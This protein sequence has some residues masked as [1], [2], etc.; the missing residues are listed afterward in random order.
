MPEG[1]QDIIREAEAANV[2]KEWDQAIEL[3][4]QVLEADP[5][6]EES[7][8]KLA[9]LYAIRGLIS[10][11]IEQ[12]FTLMDI[13]EEKD[14]HELAVEVARWIM[15][16]QPDNDKA[17]MKTILI[18]KKKGDLDEVVKQSLQLARLYIE[19][20]QGDQSILLLKNAQEI[21]PDNLDIGL[22]LAEMYISHGHIPE[23]TAQYKKIANAFLNTGNYEKAAEAFRRMKVV[24]PDDPQ[25][26][27]TLGN[28]YVN[29]G[30]L[31]EAESEFRAILRHD[32]NHTEALMAL[33]NV[34]QRKG[35]FRDAILAFNKIL[36]VDQQ[37]E[38]A[39]EKLGELY[40]A[41]G[42]TS[43]AVK[44]YLQAA[45]A[46]QYGEAVDRAIKL[47]QRV[48]TIDPTNPTAC[49]E[50]TNLGASLV[51]EEQEAE[52]IE[53]YAPVISPL[54][55]D[56]EELDITG[57]SL[58]EMAG[59]ILP[60]TTTGIPKS[61]RKAG[62]SEDEEE[63][64]PEDVI[65]REEAPIGAI[66]SQF[67]GMKSEEEEFQPFMRGVGDDL[68]YS[69]R[70]N[71]S[72]IQYREQVREQVIEEQEEVE[73]EEYIEEAPT[74]KARRPKRK[75]LR[76][77]EQY[78]QRTSRKGLVKKGLFLKEEDEKTSKPGLLRSKGKSRLGAKK[79]LFS[80]RSPTKGLLRRH[81]RG[82]EEVE[83]APE[84]EEIM[85]EV[86]EV[87]PE[88]EDVREEKVPEEYTE[89]YHEEYSEEYPEEYAE[90]YAEEYP[91]EYPSEIQ[92]EEVPQYEETITEPQPMEEPLPTPVME[93]PQPVEEYPHFE[94]MPLEE[95]QEEP[96]GFDYPEEEEPSGFA[97]V[98]G[99]LQF[100]DQ[101]LPQ[102]EEEQ[103]PEEMPT[104]EEEVV[105]EIE[106]PLAL[107][108]E[109]FQQK[110]LI[111]IKKKPLIEV[112]GVREAPTPPV[113]ELLVEEA[114]AIPQMPEEPEISQIPMMEE[115]EEEE[116][117]Y[118][119]DFAELPLLELPEEIVAEYPPE[120]EIPEMPFP[121]EEEEYSVEQFPDEFSEDMEIPDLDLSEME[122]G[123]PVEEVIPTLED[124]IPEVAEFPSALKPFEEVTPKPVEEL[125]TTEPISFEDMSLPD[126]GEGGF[127][128]PDFSSFGFE[129]PPDTGG[130][131]FTT[132]LLKLAAEIEQIIP[133]DERIREAEEKKRQEEEERK[134]WEEKKK[135]AELSIKKVPK[136]EFLPPPKVEISR[137]TTFLELPGEDEEISLSVLPSLPGDMDTGEVQIA[138]STAIT[139][140]TVFLPPLEIVIETGPPAQIVEE[141]EAPPEIEIEEEEVIGE[142]IEEPPAPE[143][144]VDIEERLR[145][146]VSAGDLG[147][148]F[149]L[150]VEAMEKKP[151]NLELRREYADLCYSYGMM[152]KALENYKILLEKETKNFEIRRKMIKGQLLYNYT[153]DAVVSLL[154]Y[155]NEL[156]GED[157]IDEAQRIYQYVLALKEKNPHA[158]ES[159][160]EIYLNLDMKELA[161]FHLKI[162]SNYLEE[163]KS[164]DRAI[165]VLRK[166][167]SLTSN[168]KIQ[169]R[170][171]RVYIENDYKDEA[172]NAIT[173]L[174]KRYMEKK[175]Y[176]K[177]ATN[178]E[179]IIEMDSQHLDAHKHLIDLYEQLGDKNRSYQEKVTVA[180]LVIAR[181]DMDEAR[182]RFEECLSIRL[183][184]Q[185]VRR[186]IVGIYLR[187][188]NLKK[189]LE[190][191]R[192]LSEFYHKQR[193]YN[194]AIELYLEL[195][196]ADPKNLALRDKLSEFYVMSDQ[197]NKGLDQLILIAEE[198]TRLAEWNQAIKAY[199]KALTIDS[200][201]P[202]LH[203][204][205][206]EIY[207]NQKK[208]VTEARY[209]FAQ[210]F[211]LD[212][213]HR[214]AMEYLVK[215][216]LREEK[217]SKATRVLKRL[218]E[219]DSSYNGMKNEIIDHYLT[220]IKKNPSDYKL[221]FYLGIVYKELRMWKQAIEQFQQTR[222]SNDY[223]LE[224][225]SM[226]GVCFAQQPPMR[227]LAIKTL[228]KGLQLPG[229][230]PK[231]YIELHYQLAL[232]YEKTRKYKKALEELQAVVSLDSYYKDAAEVLKKVK[233][234]IKY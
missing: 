164:I 54:E 6:N 88:Y 70:K 93:E 147:T 173:G 233:K 125:V 7:C 191:S 209:E 219:L 152:D 77:K 182:Q 71:G 16:L 61:A 23:G 45:N 21:A 90:E 102:V 204:K 214:K 227:N 29:L 59:A 55:L 97:D 74:R 66:P 222:K 127:D 87:E 139:P 37:N 41:Q 104:F 26:M 134:A 18:Y 43:E 130:D 89:E 31:N 82:E 100:L 68:V 86:P 76:K 116:E 12:Y 166:I 64:G 205:I 1:V 181:G 75:G 225:H 78:D 171:T 216:Y 48:L 213:T 112:I 33:G 211:E 84:M 111:G 47:Y 101:Q 132:S 151:D 20:G 91:Q 146:S 24:Q 158:R 210:V 234:K 13:L 145:E 105:E 79:G 148:A 183:D 207:L 73:E 123:E 141:I 119:E 131:D 196:K 169:E 159:L 185:E 46:Y 92:E 217:P 190:E 56:E 203:F 22:E 202:D 65:D 83:V 188:S 229:F 9:E 122:I 103:I 49:R 5:K 50:L 176:M 51:S 113:M 32:L 226:L 168:I 195:V 17:R 162:L 94:A 186:K 69:G 179:K 11:V 81:A 206:G 184:D 15:K 189:A 161:L 199:K 121:Q 155:G 224:S 124:E 34:C 172:I 128:L 36:S 106:E 201:N 60:P 218:I 154:E 44:F 63:F 150:F 120:E 231:D 136:E 99:D 192:I 35:Q 107:L 212:P 30:K 118:A 14:E 230:K 223:V 95:D 142:I 177:A 198:F 72:D 187:Q 126:L 133:D 215:L 25:L 108:D 163:E 178:Y 52:A 143:P 144:E 42:A 165:K 140:E 197:L 39:K 220:D 27:F 28:L 96:V 232:L 85:E 110:P 167:F 4:R 180:N 67:G 2:R 109:E 114:Q 137:G 53:E 153:E 160:S 98:S 57:P 19:L 208:N 115:E 10:N 156:T 58:E 193:H 117:V 3:Y 135:E 138:E 194:K 62:V 174:A 40:Q 175:Q 228:E 129:T 170:L 80:R 200:K 221:R 38:I 8:S 149:P 157:K